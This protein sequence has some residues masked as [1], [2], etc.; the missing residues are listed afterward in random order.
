MKKANA[1]DRFLAIR[2]NLT[3][4]DTT[5]ITP[6][7]RKLNNERDS[8]WTI[9]ELFDILD[10]KFKK[11]FKPHQAISIDEICV[12]YALIDQ[13]ITPK[14]DSLSENSDNASIDE[15]VDAEKKK[16]RHRHSYMFQSNTEERTSGTHFPLL[17]KSKAD[18][19][20]LIKM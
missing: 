6:E 11:Y 12:F 18:R 17:R 15:P 14:E 16:K 10:A 13:W 19:K 1:H 3:F 7:E 5:D 4:Y 8:F 2:S 20:A 9:A